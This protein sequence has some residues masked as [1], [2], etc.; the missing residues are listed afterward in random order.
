MV[1]L[2]P[3]LGSVKQE[4]MMQG[5]LSSA[6]HYAHTFIHRGQF[7]VTNPPAGMILGGGRK[8]EN[9]VET[10]MDTRTR[11]SLHR[12]EPELRIEPGSLELWSGNGTH[13]TTVP[14]PNK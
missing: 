9:P 7:S 13:C 6:G 4:Y 5:R 8:L 10:H 2:K 1:Y 12:Q 3:M 14:L 11:E